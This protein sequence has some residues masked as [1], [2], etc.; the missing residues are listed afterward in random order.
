[1][2][3]QHGKH[4]REA[5]FYAVSLIALVFTLT[6]KWHYLNCFST[7]SKIQRFSA[8]VVFVNKINDKV[9][10]NERFENKHVLPSH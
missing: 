6:T 10:H 9:I 2:Y 5:L 4:P 8:V 1:M 3:A 7:F